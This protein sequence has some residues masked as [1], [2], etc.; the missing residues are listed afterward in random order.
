VADTDTQTIAASSSAAKFSDRVWFATMSSPFHSLFD[1][2]AAIV[3]SHEVDFFCRKTLSHQHSGLLVTHA[4]K[5]RTNQA[6][7]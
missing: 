2:K 6:P 4:K 7:Q 3:W 1:K 5:E